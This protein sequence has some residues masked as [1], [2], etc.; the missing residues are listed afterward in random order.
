MRFWAPNRTNHLGIRQR[1][2]S[3][4][5]LHRLHTFNELARTL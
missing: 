3:L 2:E 5:G 1:N 4:C